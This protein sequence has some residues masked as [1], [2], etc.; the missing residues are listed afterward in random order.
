MTAEPEPTRG[1][2][3]GP[4][5]LRELVRTSARVYRRRFKA[6]AGTAAVIFAVVAMVDAL[7]DTLLDFPDRSTVV[8]L[9]FLAATSVSAL[10]STFYAGL[11]DEVVGG[12]LD[13]RPTPRFRYVVRDL[14]WLRLLVAD[15]VISV[16][17]LVTGAGF[18]VVGLV[19]FTFVCLVGPIINI[20][21]H[22]PWHAFR[23]STRLVAP[24][25]ALTL[26]FITMPVLVEHAIVHA[27]QAQVGLDAWVELVGLHA[28]LGIAIGSV[29]GLNETVLAYALIIRDH[30]RTS[31]T[32]GSPA[33]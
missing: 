29:V 9:L 16:I 18:V 4:L 17:V 14:P 10:G 24:H 2:E 8:S 11:I 28:V 13:D 23:R 12:E 26:V 31:A 15:F 27:L 1:A 19:A 5:L 3:P 32:R 33:P 22:S 6:V 25:F 30:V 7:V 21:R 20:E